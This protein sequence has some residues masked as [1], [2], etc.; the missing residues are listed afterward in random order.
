MLWC[1]S[2][3]IANKV[4][5]INLYKTYVRPVIEYGNVIWGPQY[6][7]DQ[8]EVEKVQ[9]R[10]TKLIS[11]LQDRTYDDQLAVLDLPSLKG[12]GTGGLGGYSPPTFH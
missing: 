2:D 9:R 12:G 7:L 3:N 5:L 11:D 8:Q 10:A 1:F 6:I 4:T